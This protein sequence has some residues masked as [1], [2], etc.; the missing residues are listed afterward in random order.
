MTSKTEMSMQESDEKMLGLWVWIQLK[1][2]QKCCYLSIAIL[3][4]IHSTDVNMWYCF[5]CQ[6]HSIFIWI[7]VLMKKAPSGLA[8]ARGLLFWMLMDNWGYMTHRIFF[9]K[10]RWLA[11]TMEHIN[12]LNPAGRFSGLRKQGPRNPA[13]RFSGI[14]YGVSKTRRAFKPQGLDFVPSRENHIWFSPDSF[15]RINWFSF[16][17]KID[18]TAESKSY[19]N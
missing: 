10:L 15:A 6:F 3:Y 1:V 12:P 13:G 11:E 8:I 16:Y 5:N 19:A 7:C 2:Q 18:N 4:I 17:D 9:L 14:C